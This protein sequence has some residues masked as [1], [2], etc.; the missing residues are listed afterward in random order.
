MDRL[1]A[2]LAPD[3]WLLRVALFD[4]TDGSP[5]NAAAVEYCRRHEPTKEP[6]A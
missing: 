4:D 6:Q 5:L 2:R 1:I 3:W